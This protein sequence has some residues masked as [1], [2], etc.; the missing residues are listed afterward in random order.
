MVEYGRSLTA[1]GKGM[2]DSEA[3]ELLDAYQNVKQ[4]VAYTETILCVPEG[5]GNTSAWDLLVAPINGELLTPQQVVRM[6]YRIMIMEI[7]NPERLV[8]Y[9][10]MKTIIEQV[11]K[12]EFL[13]YVAG[14]MGAV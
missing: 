5:D 11:K 2:T 13:T 10:V 6:V 14:K 8:I 9:S 4:A 1:K 7:K 3:V 12:P